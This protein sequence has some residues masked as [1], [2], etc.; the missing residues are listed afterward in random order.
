[1]LLL[2]HYVKLWLTSDAKP[3]IKILTLL[4]FGLNFL[5]ASLDITTDGW[6]FQLLKRCNVCYISI[7]NQCGG[8][9]GL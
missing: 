2:S 6:A 7:C 3:N 8:K 1:M 4:Y 5:A 9:T